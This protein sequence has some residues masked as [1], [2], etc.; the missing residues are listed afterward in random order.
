MNKHLQKHLTIR[1]SSWLAFKGQRIFSLALLILISTA[2]AWGQSPIRTPLDGDNDKA[3]KSDASYFDSYV[4][5]WYVHFYWEFDDPSGESDFERWEYAD[6][7]RDGS[8]IYLVDVNG[9]YV[10]NNKVSTLARWPLGPNQNFTLDKMRGALDNQTDAHFG[11]NKDYYLLT[12]PPKPPT[13]LQVKTTGF[14]S[15]TIEWDKN[16]DIPDQHVEY[17]VLLNGVAVAPKLPAS[18]REHTFT[19]L[20]SATLYTLGIR[21]TSKAGAIT[22]DG[23]TINFQA[24]SGNTVNVGATTQQL[25][26][27]VSKGTFPDKVRL[28]W[29]SIAGSDAVN[30]RVER[31]PK[32]IVAASAF[33]EQT[34]L[35]N[36]ATA[37]NDTDAIPGLEYDY[38]VSALNASG[39]T[40]SSVIGQGYMKPNGI[41]KGTIRSKAGTGVAGVRVCVV[42]KDPINP[43]SPVP[44]PNGGYCATTQAGGDYEIRN[45]YYYDS[46]TFIVQPTYLNHTFD[47]V[48]KKVILDINA[49]RQTGIDFLDE[50]AITVGG[51]VKFPPASQ[52]FN[53]SASK[54]WG[55][56]GVNILIDGLDQG[57]VTDAEGKW[58][59]ALTDPATVTIEPQHPSHT[60]L[61]A[62]RTEMIGS[63]DKLDVDFVDQTVDDLH[64]NVLDACGDSLAL[65]G[66]VISFI[67]EAKLGADYYHAS[68]PT[69]LDGTARLTLPATNY[70]LSIDPTSQPKFNNLKYPTAFA[71][72]DT[73]DLIVNMAVRDTLTTTT[74]T[75]RIVKI[76]PERTVVINGLTVT[77]PK[78]TT[79]ATEK[80]VE[81]IAIQPLADFTYF[82]PLE[83]ELD[84]QKA[85][86]EVFTCNYTPNIPEVIVLQDG[87]RYGLK[88]RVIEKA[89]GC[90]VERGTVQ[91]YDELGD[92]KKPITQQ[93]KNGEVLY[94]LKAGKPNPAIGGGHPNMKSI[95]FY[96]EAGV[97]PAEGIGYW[98]LIEG[99]FDASQTFVSRSPEIPDLIV[100]DPPGDGSYAW[101]SEGS[102][103]STFTQT[104]YEESNSNGGYSDV[105][106]G[107]KVTTEI[108][109]GFAQEFEV[110]AGIEVK[111]DLEEGREEFNSKGIV[112]TYTFTNTFSTSTFPLFT[113]HNGD[114]Y[115]G[116]SFNQHF[117]DAD[118]VLFDEINCQ[119]IVKPTISMAP[120]K[121]ATTFIYSE[122]HIK[123][124]LLMQLGFLQENI[125]KEA[126]KL[127]AEGKKAEAEVKFKEA[128]DFK[129][130]IKTWNEI[131]DYNAKNRNEA[132]FIENISFSAGAILERTEINTDQ[133]SA[134]Y[135]YTTF[136]D[137][138]TSTGAVIVQE[139][140]IWNE[141]SGGTAGH[142]RRTSTEIESKDTT[143]SFEIGFALEDNEP[144]D[145]FS[146][147]LKK[148][149]KYGTYVFD[150][151][152]GN[153]ACPTEP[154]TKN[155]DKAK[156]D[157]A[158]PF[159]S[160]VPVGE[161]AK[162]T[163]SLTN[164]SQSRESREYHVRVIGVSNP[165]GL[166]VSLGGWPI[167]NQPAS[168]FLDYGQ[169][170][171]ITMSVARGPN[172]ANYK[173]VQLIM[174]PPCEYE[175]W[176]DGGSIPSSDTASFQLTFQTECTFANI[177]QP[178]DGWLING[179]S[180][181][182]LLLGLSGYD[183]RNP[184][185]EKVVIEFKPDGQGWQFGTEIYRSKTGNASQDSIWDTEAF[186]NWNLSNL[187]DGSY[188]IRAV[189]HC[190]GG[191]GKTI[192]DAQRL[193][194]DRASVEPFGRPSPADGFL[195]FGQEISITFDQD[196]K[197]N[198]A[199]YDPQG[200]PQPKVELKNTKTGALIPINRQCSEGQDKIIL[201]PIEDIFQKPELEGVVLEATVLGIQNPS[202]NVQKYP[203]IWKF[204]ANVSPV[205][206]DPDTLRF[207]FVQGHPKPVSATLKNT[208][209][210][211]KSF[212]IT[213]VPNIV[214]P[215]VLSGS[216]LSNGE[217]IVEFMPNPALKAGTYTESVTASIDG[218]EERLVIAITVDAHQPNWVV[219][220]EDFEYSMTVVAAM[221]LDNTNNNLS[222]DE[223]DLVAVLYNGEVRGL[224]KL[225]YVPEV[226]KHLA[227]IN[228]Y[229]NIPANEQMDFLLWRASTGVE[230]IALETLYFGQNIIKGTLTTPEILHPNGVFQ[231]IPLQKGWNWVSLNVTN[232]NNTVHNLLKSLSSPK[233]GNDVLVKRKDGQTALFTQIA[234]PIIYANQWS[235]PLQELDN[236][237]GYMIRLSHAP[238]TLRIPGRP[239]TT[240]QPIDLLSGWNWIG[241]QPQEAKPIKE[242]MASV[243][244]RN[245]D[246]M[247]SRDAF[248]EYRNADKKWIGPLQFM[249]PGQGYRL[250]LK[251][252]KTYNDL[253]YSRL[254]LDDFKVDHTKYESNMT[255]IGSVG[256]GE[257]RGEIRE[258]RLLVGAFIDDT[259]R[260]YGYV[261]YVEFLE[262]YRV[263]FSLNGNASDM[264]RKLTFKVY[265]TQSG[266]EFISDK[267]EELY[268][269]DHILGGMMEPFVLFERL[270]LPEVGYL[271]EQNYPNPYDAKTNIRFILP[272]AGP[273]KLTVYDQ[274]GK[275]V[276]VL[277]DEELSAGEHTAVFE[278][279]NLPAGVYHYTIEAGEF[280]ASRKMVRM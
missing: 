187:A 72:L 195:R 10:G 139:G 23:Y 146:I 86:A 112:S 226:N 215:G 80:K 124:V 150:L 263:I 266:Q 154:G 244:I 107:G 257:P 148:D 166:T 180:S 202:G 21:T 36:Q 136:L 108:G 159:Q 81:K 16:T 17:E 43:G 186:L 83:F 152:G 131:L 229:S 15:I 240:F 39:T 222:T 168:F 181:P 1:I 174:Y 130:D 120:G 262:E 6:G 69:Q 143:K 125:E 76:T 198:F 116:T 232:T 106:L 190:K 33:A 208:A 149:K 172:A 216:V 259:C 252:G 224:A 13:N 18:A 61:P 210:L 164:L 233:V 118:V 162:F 4:S 30:L 274:M 24:A 123:D 265:D 66:Q 113:G 270:E 117:V 221:S 236:K 19:G 209:G 88:L 253:L 188:Q 173:D 53:G 68:I 132:T 111:T 275:T 32:H 192:S 74:T 185:M 87:G 95:Y 109:L 138:S 235:G 153:S 151:K 260:G 142:F 133:V 203:A 276:K 205:F 201:E 271:L 77:L 213:Q 129:N 175:L 267:Q 22:Y 237:N 114:V 20:A 100:H 217:Y 163:V 199:Q 211:T 256:V 48:S 167:N 230:H 67:L 82:G 158:S 145:F 51:Q 223:R 8:A 160:N 12:L 94:V 49:K 155:R 104:E 89:S 144:G 225:T 42:P 119:T 219:R 93:V 84:W 101:V 169:T 7:A 47:P 65:A 170:S 2:F 45:I 255:L 57:V 212:K 5:D 35:S 40:V 92:I 25:A 121:V 103:I 176:Q 96:V 243:N 38:R 27:N 26:M 134:S 189:T 91:V 62:S 59:Y 54:I 9:S 147:D 3:I 207:S 55:M 228:V 50:S 115:I 126:E 184:Y 70:K 28:E 264:G 127:K 278:A 122:K 242:A 214:T 137:T 196:I 251:V 34:I 64:V 102:E 194:I 241:Y 191:R 272:E 29:P 105:L 31:K 245:K 56:A 254:G 277:V 227:F 63:T 177:T 239:I 41:L 140:G 268:V 99:A 246:L 200:S 110:G 78:D 128:G 97:R 161:E 250:S 261:E 197:C 165:D 60:F 11:N 98:A 234:T 157:I 279:A 249:E 141:N 71:Q 258:E 58:S 183:I 171:E 220:P 231:V 135:E 178:A 238:D 247:R 218:F 204:K 73:I 37:W 85:G 182:N 52:Y 14:A 269:S 206:W 280:R 90:P 248:S 179:N 75:R 79:W 193:L 156:I 273:V 44:V 46:A